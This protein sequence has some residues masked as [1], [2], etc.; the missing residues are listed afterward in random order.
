MRALFALAC[1]A[2]VGCT[3]PPPPEHDL[4][5]YSGIRSLVSLGDTEAQMRQRSE[6][7][8]ERTP[9]SAEPGLEKAGIS[10]IFTFKDRG[11]RVYFKGGRAVWI[12]MQEPFRGTIQGKK[13][14]IFT[15]AAPGEKT[16]EEILVR[17]L[18]EP[19]ARAA[20]G[21]LGSEALFYPW[22]D[23]S[24]NKMGPNEVALYRDQEIARMRLRN[25]GRDVKFFPSEK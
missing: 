3:E 18:G 7:A 13:L 4:S 2:L 23:I 19:S 12:A 8:P 24:Y 9:A 25:F 20:G 22:G 16:W 14:K 15:F 10:H 11:T 5:L 1:L 17:E 6:L 21:R